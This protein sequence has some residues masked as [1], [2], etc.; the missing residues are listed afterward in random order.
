M[1]RSGWKIEFAGWDVK[2]K[3]VWSRKWEF[4]RRKWDPSSSQK[5]RDYAAAKDAASAK[6]FEITA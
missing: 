3:G 6:G 2:G 5:K 4:G 1:T